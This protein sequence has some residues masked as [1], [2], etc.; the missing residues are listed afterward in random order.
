MN[1]VPAWD[2]CENEFSSRMGQSSVINSATG[3]I[4]A[5]VSTGTQTVH[6]GAMN[7]LRGHS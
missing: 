2:T 6:G 4:N 5:V 7:T 1:P 3:R